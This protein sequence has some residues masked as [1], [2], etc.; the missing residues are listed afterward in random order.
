MIYVNNLTY[1]P[2]R[3][4]TSLNLPWTGKLWRLPVY[5]LPRGTKSTAWLTITTNANGVDSVS[6][7][8]ERVYENPDRFTQTREGTFYVSIRH[9][10][11]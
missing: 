5:E 3:R 7:H 10:G 1:P 8:R 6:Y 4:I 9:L 11:A 2:E